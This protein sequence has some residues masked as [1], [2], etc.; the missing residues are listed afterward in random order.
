MEYE[1][2]YARSGELS[3]AYQVIGDGP[4]D[5]VYAPP[6]ISHVE[7][8]HEL[9]GYT[10]FLEALGRFARVIVFD[11]R[12]T[13][14]SDRPPA[15]STLEERID[16]LRAVMDEV[17]SER[18]A[19]LGFSEA[20]PLAVMYAATYPD[21]VSHLVL[22]GTFAA[23]L[24]DPAEGAMA[25]PEVGIQMIESILDNWGTGLFGATI[26]PSIATNPQQRAVLG[27]IERYSATPQ[28]ARLLFES[29]KRV[30]VRALLPTVQVPTLVVRRSDETTPKW[31]CRYLADHIPGAIYCEVPGIDH[32][33]AVGDRQAYIDVMEDF[34]TGS[35]RD[36]RPV[37][38]TV[39]A[40]VLF[41][42]IVGSTER[43]AS[44]GDRQWRELLDRFRAKVRHEIE[45]HRGREVN[46]RGDDFL[47]AFDGPARAVRCGFAIA[48]VAQ[49][50]GISVRTGVH[51]GECEVL[52]DDLAGIAV[53]IGAR[54]AGLAGAGEVLVTSTVRD[55]VFGSGLGFD[56]RGEHELKGVPGRWR[57]L[58][59]VI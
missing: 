30:D 40:T 20:G 21:R 53:H 16:D 58:A 11:K 5:L 59:A 12:G 9:P 54:V 49:R 17:G 36:D 46:T 35:S 44:M 31:A 2:R 39:L 55:L 15:V 28:G 38:E 3:I 41:T 4:I 52:G 27:R 7:F 48:D 14:L 25:V 50:L 10:D 18:A 23:C 32:V 6:I 33:P 22:C 37:L 24:G 51:T 47:I 8:F 43:A 45:R 13:G 34:L 56:D 29:M 57:L 1:T 42:D 26:C 19:V